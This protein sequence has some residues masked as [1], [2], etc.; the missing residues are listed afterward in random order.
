MV[1]RRILPTFGTE[2]LVSLL[3]LGAFQ[4]VDAQPDSAEG[5]MD[6]SG[7]SSASTILGGYGNAFYQRNFDSR[8]STIDL[9]RFVLFVGHEFT[10][11]ISLFSELEVED[12][13]VTGG[14]EGGE[15]SIEQA[16]LK[17]DLDAHHSVV[18][19]LFLPRIGILNENHLPPSFNGNERTIV[20]TLVI[21]ATWRELGVGFYGMLAPFQLSYSIGVMNG[22][23][24]SGFQHGSLIREGRFEGRNASANNL[25]LTGSLQA[26]RGQFQVQLSGYYGGSVG[27]S[28]HQADSLQLASGFFGTPVLLGE[29]DVQYQSKGLSVKLLGTVVSIPD[30]D[31]INRAFA[32]NTPTTAFGAYL[33]VGY[34][35]LS[36]A[37]G[38][39][40]SQ[41]ILFGRVERLDL[42]ARIPSNG[43]AD[44]TLNQRHITL[45]I[46]YLP[47]PNIVL[48]ADVR[49]MHTGDLN[50]ALVVNPDLNAPSYVPNNTYFNLGIGF[51]F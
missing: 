47:N 28:P 35:I 11:T 32:N 42:N 44:P 30:A 33:E 21:P 3:L 40:Q 8:T 9:E 29:A 46:T 27:L 31:K 36:P 43:I 41:L 39:Q 17:F 5:N 10:P 26:S 2:V 12:A 7:Q 1:A 49:L 20:E 25:A 37:E 13:K 24:A 18:A 15:V 51:A 22:L 19:G 48:K 14:E 34:D 6:T 45:G 38:P 4:S 50:P 23:A 16:Y